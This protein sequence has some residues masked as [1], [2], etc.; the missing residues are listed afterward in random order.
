[1]V[2][3]AMDDYFRQKAEN[4]GIY[5][6]NGPFVRLVMASGKAVLSFPKK[7]RLQYNTQGGGTWESDRPS[8]AKRDAKISFSGPPSSVFLKIQENGR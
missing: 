8:S 5:S 4:P 1:M 2:D 3:F 6:N 7:A